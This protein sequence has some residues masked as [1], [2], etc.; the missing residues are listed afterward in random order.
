MTE[1]QIKKA[2]A[3]ILEREQAY[4]DMINNWSKSNVQVDK[5]DAQITWPE[6]TLV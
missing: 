3:D 5:K 1:E 4:I 2:H 6:I